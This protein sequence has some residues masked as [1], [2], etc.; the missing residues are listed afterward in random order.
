[1]ANDEWITP[2]E[3]L[4]DVR[5]F[6]GG[7]ITCDP[8]SSH[9]ANERFVQAEIFYD[10][11]RDGLSSEWFGNV[12]CNPP[13]STQ[14]CNSFTSKFRS[15]QASVSE[16]ILLINFDCSTIRCQALLKE[17]SYC[18]VGK[19]IAFIDPTTLQ[20]TKG[21]RHSQALFYIGKRRMEFVSHFSNW[22]FSQR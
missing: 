4:E 3:L 11:E 1:M 13:Y 18:L 14:L 6:Y 19:R 20:P 5:K 10:K 15:S 17:S 7:S 16:K 22:G 9:T 2:P 8:A 12:F 21:N